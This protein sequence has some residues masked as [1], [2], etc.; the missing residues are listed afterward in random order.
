MGFQDVDGGGSGS[1]SP[2]ASKTLK[3][4]LCVNVKQVRAGIKNGTHFLDENKAIIKK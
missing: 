3:P 2:R 4:T 1:I